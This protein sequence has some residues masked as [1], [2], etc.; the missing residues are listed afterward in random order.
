M[1]AKNEWFG[2][3]K[4]LWWWVSPKTW[5][6]WLYIWVMVLIL[7]W[8]QSLGFWTESQK[9]Y[10]AIWWVTFLLVD[11]IPIMV[12]IKR[13]EREYKIE[14]VSERNAA[15]IMSLVLTIWIVYQVF[16]SWLKWEINVDYFLI[17][18]LIA[19]VIV[20]SISNFVL[21]RKGE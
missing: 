1:I 4:Y 7:V 19:W 12:N 5:Q 21:E 16:T 10:I 13:D 17:F 20:K 15:W 9:N 18:A 14:A 6:W 2:R 3:R 11:I 8:I